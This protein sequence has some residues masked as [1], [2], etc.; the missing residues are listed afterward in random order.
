MNRIFTTNFLLA[1][2]MLASLF[3][4][5]FAQ[6]DRYQ[7]LQCK[8]DIPDDFTKL[9]SQK[10]S[11]DVTKSGLVSSRDKKKRQFLLTVNAYQDELLL[12]GLILF[13]DPIT[14]YVNKVMDNLLLHDPALRKQVR[15]YVI[16]TPYVN[17][18]AF[19]NG[20][21]CVTIGLL[22]RLQN[23]AQ[24]AF[25]LA[26]EI[27]HFKEKHGMKRYEY[28]AEH[29]K[30]LK[31]K[32]IEDRLLARNNYSQEH[33]LEAD[34]DGLRLLEKSPYSTSVSIEAMDILRDTE[35]PRENMYL[36]LEMMQPAWAGLPKDMVLDEVP[37][38]DTLDE[39]YDD[40]NH[41]HPN[42]YRRKE[43]LTETISDI[44]NNNG[45]L[46]VQPR[47]DF[48]K[49][50]IAAQLENAYIL[51]SQGNYLQ[52]GYEAYLLSMNYPDVPYGQQMYLYANYAFAKYALND[53]RYKVLNSSM[54]VGGEQDKL[55]RIMD[56]ATAKDIAA[57]SIYNLLE[58]GR[59]KDSTE[60]NVYVYDLVKTL[61]YEEDL[62]AGMLHSDSVVYDD[63]LHTEN[64][65]L[66]VLKNYAEHPVVK[67]AL[68]ECE[69]GADS[70]KAFEEMLDLMTRKERKHYMKQGK[71]QL[72]EHKKSKEMSGIDKVV[73]DV[74]DCYNVRVT[75]KKV[76]PDYLRA[77]EDEQKLTTIMK[78][79]AEKNGIQMQVL[80]PKEMS[81]S[82]VSAFNDLSALKNW[83]GYQFVHVGNSVTLEPM[84]REAVKGF[85]EKYDTKYFALSQVISVKERR[86]NRVG[87]LLFTC[88]FIYGLPISIYRFSPKKFT[89][90]TFVVLDIENST[91]KALLKKEL[92]TTGTNVNFR[93]ATY[94]MM[95][96][97]KYKRNTILLKKNK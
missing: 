64:W 13:G 47:A 65:W 96:Q 12:S 14:E 88:V 37:A 33:E 25:V 1:L 71:E 61:M 23:E 4:Q 19:D 42:I 22:S 49:I 62:R 11:Q 35:L 87:T 10:F 15:V 93:S 7:P 86:R 2:L 70:L 30:E 66:Y 45:K 95:Y 50:L 54:S 32:S 8:G 5:S 74:P 60:N 82:E 76:K 3:V 20:L 59:A 56:N 85:M 91:V 58:N 77:E 16:K 41:S 24:L 72:K 40:D 17:A 89:R 29:R 31:N 43:A 39:D 21:I 90:I 94:D 26:H 48:D 67:R 78:E 84:D 75:H 55:Y 38:L 68:I 18:F 80:N 6:M 46:F 34:N 57:L 81:A 73:M 52:G 97:L 79:A 83:L 69:A 44:K 28:A 36:A 51:I 9:Y 63:S 92:T 53:K 27:T